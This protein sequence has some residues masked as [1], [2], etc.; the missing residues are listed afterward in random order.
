MRPFCIVKSWSLFGIQ[1][2]NIPGL[3]GVVIPEW[4]GVKKRE[5]VKIEEW[6][7]QKYQEARHH[8]GSP[9]VCPVKRCHSWWVLPRNKG[10]LCQSGLCWKSGSHQ[11]SSAKDADSLERAQKRASQII[12]KAIV[13]QLLSCVWLF[14]TPWTATRQTSLSITIF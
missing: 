4:K 1:N 2:G 8:L 10:H 12:Q 13:V 11:S 5:S 14:V 7:E 9:P 6:R 3:W